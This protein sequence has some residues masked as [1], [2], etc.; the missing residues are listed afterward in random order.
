MTQFGI[1]HE[2]ILKVI[3]SFMGDSIYMFA[4]DNDEENILSHGDTEFHN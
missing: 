2:G 1:F 4:L 3:F